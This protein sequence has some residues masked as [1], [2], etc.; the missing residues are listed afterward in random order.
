MFL[1]LELRQ[2]TAAVRLSAAQYLANEQAEINRLSIDREFIEL[3]LKQNSEGY[4]ALS[5]VEK[6]Q[7]QGRNRSVLRFVRQCVV[8]DCETIP[9]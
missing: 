8:A 4:Q 5:D 3:I 9:R 2:N 6:L 7:I 1:A